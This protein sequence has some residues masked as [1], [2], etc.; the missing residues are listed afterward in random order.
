LSGSRDQGHQTQ[1][2]LKGLINVNLFLIKTVYECLANTI[3]NIQ[4]RYQLYTDISTE[5]NYLPVDINMLSY[6]CT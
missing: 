3:H 6:L 2:H 5:L 4:I 1:L